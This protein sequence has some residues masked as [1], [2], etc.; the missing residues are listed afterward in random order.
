SSRER[1]SGGAPLMWHLLGFVTS[2][3]AAHE[4][5]LRAAGSLRRSPGRHLYGTGPVWG[6]PT[7]S[8]PVVDLARIGHRLEGPGPA[9]GTANARTRPEHGPGLRAPARR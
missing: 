7:A 2:K 3:E 1:S 5:R 9:G 8:C 6:R 4:G